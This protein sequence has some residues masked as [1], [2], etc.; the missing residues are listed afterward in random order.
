MKPETCSIFAHPNEPAKGTH[1]ALSCQ[2]CLGV[3]RVVH[4]P[5]RTFM[6]VAASLRCNVCYADERDPRQIDRR[7]NSVT[8]GGQKLALHFGAGPA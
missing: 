2:S 6:R 4:P 8:K 3:C 5:D 7:C 1:S